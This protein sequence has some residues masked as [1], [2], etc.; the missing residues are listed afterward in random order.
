MASDGE[1]TQWRREVF[2]DPYLV[3]HDGPDFAVLLAMARSDLE[4]VGRMLAAGVQRPR[5]AR[6]AVVRVSVR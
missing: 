1:W 3:W 6:R 5:P 2:G 4:A